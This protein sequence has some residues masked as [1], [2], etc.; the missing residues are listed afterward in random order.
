[1]AKVSGTKYRELEIYV[2]GD[3]A[4]YIENKE[5][6]KDYA[7]RLASDALSKQ[8]ENFYEQLKTVTELHETLIDR[9]W[10][11]SENVRARC[12]WPWEVSLMSRLSNS[13]KS[14]KAKQ[15]SMET[16]FEHLERLADAERHARPAGSR[17]GGTGFD[18][19]TNLWSS[20]LFAIFF[21]EADTMEGLWQS[22][23][24]QPVLSMINMA[25]GYDQVHSEPCMSTCT[26]LG[27]AS[28][29]VVILIPGWSDENT[30]TF[31][32]WRDR[33]PQEWPLAQI[34]DA[35]PRGTQRPR[36]V[37]MIANE[38]ELNLIEE[39]ATNS[40]FVVWTDRQ[41]RR[42]TFWKFLGSCICRFRYLL[43]SD[44][45]EQQE[46]VDALRSTGHF[47]G[48]ENPPAHIFPRSNAVPR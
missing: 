40:T 11:F 27:S 35:M 22:N 41:A 31:N 47:M 20:R 46:F 12:S 37:L 45:R 6:T 33:I 48:N 42:E 30:L 3:G 43:R 19:E 7:N 17:A 5:Q 26:E 44:S 28:P 1:M 13:L 21:L 38:C 18:Q 8:V 36:C 2:N 39:R 15:K 29:G 14:V 23:E 24:F 9:Q 4:I 16:S 34:L 32:F 25:V 10:T